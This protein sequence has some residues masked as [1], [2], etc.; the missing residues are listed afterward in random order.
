[1]AEFIRHAGV[2]ADEMGFQVYLVGGFVRDL[3]LGVGHFD[4]DLVVEGDGIRF[5]QECA[6]RLSLKV[7]THG[8]FGTAT[9]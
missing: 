3:L 6:R 8:R 5:A 7:V 4:I 2:L 1:M 9:L